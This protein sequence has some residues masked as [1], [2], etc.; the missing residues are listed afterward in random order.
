MPKKGKG[1]TDGPKSRLGF[2]AVVDTYYASD[3]DLQIVQNF[4]SGM[5]I[6]DTLH[7]PYCNK[8]IYLALHE[9]FDLISIIPIAGTTIEVPEYNLHLVAT[10]TG[11]EL[12]T[13]ERVKTPLSADYINSQTNFKDGVLWRDRVMR[14][15]KLLLAN[16]K[17]SELSNQSEKSVEPTLEETIRDKVKKLYKTPLAKAEEPVI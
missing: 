16:S 1:L 14:V 3:K 15:V 12:S 11:Y 5:V 10:D 13:I 9:K 6:L 8:V 2:F 4:M 17:W 7:L